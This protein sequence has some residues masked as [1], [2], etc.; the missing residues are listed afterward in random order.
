[1]VAVVTIANLWQP[2][3]FLF[4]LVPVV[5]DL[6]PF[7]TLRVELPVAEPATSTDLS[8]VVMKSLPKILC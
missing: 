5:A 8:V 7:A 6:S 4:F 2:V 3:A 1:V